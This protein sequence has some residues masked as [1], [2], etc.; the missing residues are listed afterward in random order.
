MQGVGESQSAITQLSAPQV[1]H[2]G[3]GTDVRY[4]QPALTRT[5]DRRSWPAR[6]RVG[7]LGGSDERAGC[8]GELQ[9]D[10]RER[11][12]GAAH[13]AQC[14]RDVG[15][16]DEPQHGEPQGSHRGERPGRRSRAHLGT[17]VGRLLPPAT[18]PWAVLH[19]LATDNEDDD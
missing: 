18:R 14:L 13:H 12:L 16:T 11:T 6:I 8:D 4:G 17:A 19:L 2:A 10:Q 15:R 9:A 5:V 7:A 3:A 1:E